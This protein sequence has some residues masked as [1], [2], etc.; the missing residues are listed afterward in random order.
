MQ[1]TCIYATLLDEMWIKGLII[2]RLG[3]IKV[4][5]YQGRVDKGGFD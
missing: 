4:Y 2:P 5:Y 3:I 1:D